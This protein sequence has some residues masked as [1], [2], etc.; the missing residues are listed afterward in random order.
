MKSFYIAKIKV[1]PRLV[2]RIALFL[3]PS[4]ENGGWNPLMP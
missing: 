1:F 3:L 2:V 4:Y